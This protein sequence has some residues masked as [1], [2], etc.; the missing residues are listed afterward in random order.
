MYK[1]KMIIKVLTFIACIA[2]ILTGCKKFEHYEDTGITNAK[3]DGS[4]MQYLDSKPFQF[5]TLSQVI[6][7]AGMEEVFSKEE[8]TFF[9]PQD[10]SIGAVIDNLNAYLRLTGRDSVRT[11]SDIK[12][13][14]WKEMLSMYIF[15]GTNRLKDYR[16]VDTLALDTYSGQG[17]LAYNG[18]PMNIGVVFN[19][20]VN[21]PVDNRT[22]IKYGGYRQLMLSYIPDLAYPKAFWINAKVSSSDINPTN[23]IV[24]AIKFSNHFFGFYPYNFITVALENGIGE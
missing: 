24:H 6:R 15:K 12:P 21:G 2:F 23:G 14:A 7:L 22:T 17:Y 5:D 16:Q 20:A 1:Y 18:K 10:P 13:K 3:F 8:I 4:I 19:D 9:A 11:L